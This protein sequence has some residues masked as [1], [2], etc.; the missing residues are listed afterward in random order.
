VNRLNILVLYGANATFTNTVMEHARSFG[1]FSRHHVRYASVAP[2]VPRALRELAQFDVVVLHYSFFPGLAWNVPREVAAALAGCGGLKILFLQ[3]EYDHTD[4]ARSW[5]EK[6]GIHC[7][8]TCVPA[9]SRPQVYSPQRFAHLDFRETLTGYVPLAPPDVA[10]P[11]PG[12]RVFVVGYRGRQLHPRYG[13]L[14]REKWFIGERMREICL[15]R[16][17][18]A[19]IHTSDDERIYGRGW[20]EFLAHCR[21]TLGTESGSNVLDADGS[22]RARIDA[23]VAADRTLTYEEIHA[24]FIGAREGAIR[25][26]QVSPR[27]FEAVAMRTALILFEGDYSGVVTPWEHYLPLRKDFSNADDLLRRLEDLAEVEAMTARAHR[28]VIASGRFSYESFVREFDDYVET[29]AE[30]R[31]SAAVPAQSIEAPAGPEEV[32]FMK[33]APEG[34][35]DTPFK[36]EWLVPAARTPRGLEEGLRRVYRAV[37]RGLR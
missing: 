5:I 3:D 37:R 26:N 6:L 9:L 35:T 4:A 7:L 24:R 18:R 33:A 14:A 17:V 16:G 20:Y 25:M 12:E 28:H 11:P 1:L 29:R 32:A 30:P 31:G 2:R 15:R 19:D 13:D 23:A 34:P 8:Y 27:I 21:A 10:C 36:V 22:L